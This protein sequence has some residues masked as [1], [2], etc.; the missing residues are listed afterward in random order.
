MLGPCRA[1]ALVL[2]HSVVLHMDLRT[3]ALLVRTNGCHLTPLLLTPASTPTPTTLQ[4]E[5]MTRHYKTAILLIEFDA[6]RAFAL[7][8]PSE[9]G[10]DID[11]RNV[12]SRLALLLLHHPR[13]RLLWSRS[14]H[15]TADMF[16][17][18]KANQD[19]PDAAAAALVGVPVGPDGQPVP[20][21]AQPQLATAACAF[22]QASFHQHALPAAQSTAARLTHSTYMCHLARGTCFPS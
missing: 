3:A 17:A 11:H 10:P 13:L 20:V 15:A 18:F 4:A 16:L 14:L 19:E 7:Q 1:A 8:S 12:I 5:S 9:M 6:D 2:S 21:S 22:Q